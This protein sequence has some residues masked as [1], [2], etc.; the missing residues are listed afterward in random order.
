[1]KESFWKKFLLTGFG[2]VLTAIIGSSATYYFQ[3]R[4]WEH[5]HEISL[6]ESETEAASKIF[7]ETS[8]LVDKRIYRME[9]LNWWLED[10]KD[11]KR[12][13]EQMDMYRQILYEWNDNF[14]RNRA[15]ME[16]YFGKNVQDYY[17]NDIHSAMKNAG[18]L[19]GDYY[20][21]S[22]WKRSRAAGLEIEGR[23]G[24]LENKAYELNV[25]MLK[26]IQKQEVGVFNPEVNNK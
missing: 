6:Q 17:S 10:N 1:M 8:K 4:A 25:R 12:I 15:L 3:N 21:T 7:E 9:Q 22:S 24:D 13:E 26:L 2:I 19:L 16:R 14:N 23:V 11:Q 20:Y 18:N 5:Q